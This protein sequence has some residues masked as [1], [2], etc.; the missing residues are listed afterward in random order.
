[1]HS[2]PCHCGLTRACRKP[3]F[4][5]SFQGFRL[6]RFLSVNGH[7]FLAPKWQV[8]PFL[9]LLSCL[10]LSLCP[11]LPFQPTAPNCTWCFWFQLLAAQ[12]FLQVPL[13]WMVV[14]RL[15]WFRTHL[16]FI[17]SICVYWVLMKI[18]LLIYAVLYFAYGFWTLL[19]SAATISLL[20]FYYLWLINRW[21]APFG[22]LTIPW[23]CF[24]S[25]FLI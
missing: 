16:R 21:I 8:W 4:F 14:L 11:L 23:R 2:I 7:L 3:A 24:L 17:I 10:L 5:G 12:F 25:L 22:L 19:L 6:F 1:M 20:S 15:D 18:W 9:F 13:L